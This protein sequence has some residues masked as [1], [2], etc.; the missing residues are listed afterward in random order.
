V[1][2]VVDLD[3]GIDF[4]V[5]VVHDATDT[6]VEV[7]GGLSTGSIRTSAPFPEF[8]LSIVGLGGGLRARL[9]P[10]VG[11]DITRDIDVDVNDSEI[12]GSFSLPASDDPANPRGI[13]VQDGALI[14][15]LIANLGLELIDG[16]TVRAAQI[17]LT[18]NTDQHRLDL[19]A[20]IADFKV[21]PSD[22]DCFRVTGAQVQVY[23]HPETKIFHLQGDFVRAQSFGNF[24]VDL[25]NSIADLDLNSHTLTVTVNS[26][27]N[28]SYFTLLN[29]QDLSTIS[30]QEINVYKHFLISIEGGNSFYAVA[31]WHIPWTNYPIHGV[32]YTSFSLLEAQP[33]TGVFQR[34]ITP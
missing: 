16:L 11:L 8:E 34:A 24:R 10:Y 18:F 2:L 32:I 14:S 19:N 27:I 33:R 20:S 5:V 22:A 31:D 15:N 17:G 21:G 3:A 25:Q 9:R 23:Y 12:Q 4:N 30:G 28:L 7:N 6:Y 29:D 13:R 1:L 26:D